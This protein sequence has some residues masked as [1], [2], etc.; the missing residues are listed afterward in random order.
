MDQKPIRVEQGPRKSGRHRTKTAGDKE[1][2]VEEG[3]RRGHQER[4]HLP[5]K[6]DHTGTPPS[7]Q[8][9]LFLTEPETEDAMIVRKGFNCLSCS[10]R[11]E[12]L[13]GRIGP[14]LNWNNM[15]STNY[16]PPRVGYSKPMGEHT[17]DKEEDL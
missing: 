13:R 6:Q 17:G 3:R 7:I 2:P 15:T 4:L 11:V 14:K 12:K 8:L 5:G 9:Y 16:S 10:K 1:I